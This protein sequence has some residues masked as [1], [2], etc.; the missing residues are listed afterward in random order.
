MA[1]HGGSS[2]GHL[3]KPRRARGR[4]VGVEER[5]SLILV[6][7]HEMTV[8]IERDRD[9]GRRRDAAAATF[10]IEVCRPS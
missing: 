10:V 2:R 4:E 8:A 5:S 7:G 3:R 9:G 1:G 6:S